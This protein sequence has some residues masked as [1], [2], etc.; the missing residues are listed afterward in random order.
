MTCGLEHSFLHHGI[1]KC[2]VGMDDQSW[3]LHES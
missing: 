1:G 3:E 2:G